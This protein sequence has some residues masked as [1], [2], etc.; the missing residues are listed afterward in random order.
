MVQPFPSDL[1]FTVRT[2]EPELISPA[3]STPHEV[4]LLP[5][6]DNQD[7][8]CIQIPF[9]HL[10]HPKPSIAGKDPVTVIKEALAQTL[11]FY[12]PFAG[13][14]KEGE[15]RKLMVECNREGV[16][17]IEA[18]ANITLQ[19][20]GDDLHPPFPYFQDLLYSPPGLDKILHCPILLILVSYIL[21]SN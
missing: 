13:R 18:D 3:K 12:Y 11:V 20:F 7:A 8:L 9:I 16:I 19:E 6:R 10:H 1:V 5:N 21:L 4:K 15:G 17:F 2:K 14:L